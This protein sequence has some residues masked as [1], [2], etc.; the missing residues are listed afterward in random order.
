MREDVV[1]DEEWERNSGKRKLEI[2]SYQSSCLKI[3]ED[4]N[5]KEKPWEFKA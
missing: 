5:V 1:K 2:L 3:G 4:K